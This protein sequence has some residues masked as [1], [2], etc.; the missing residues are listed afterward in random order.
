MKLPYLAVSLVAFLLTAI[1]CAPPPP[2][3]H[4]VAP[5]TPTTA[6]TK[7]VLLYSLAFTAEGE[8]QYDPNGPFREVLERLTQDFQVRYSDQPLSWKTLGGAK[9][10]LI[11]NPCDKA[12]EG[13]A[14][15]RHVSQED[16]HLLTNYVQGGG[17]LIF[18]SNQSEAHNCE[19]RQANFLLNQF[20]MGVTEYTIGV[21]KVQIPADAPIVGGLTWAFYYGSPLMVNESHF[22][23]PRVLVWNDPNVPAEPKKGADGLRGPILA[24][25][26]VG[27]GRV[28]LASDSGW[29]AQWALLEQEPLGT[30]RGQDNWEIFRRLARWTAGMKPIAPTT[31][32]Q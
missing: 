30:L 15:P 32:P 20:G 8:K 21:K 12:F 31:Q 24:V 1:C 3:F 7:P 10:V 2:A 13:H 6:A 18:L 5:R 23:H 28:V 19:K 17:G 14:P 9:V 26:E 29:I 11:A 4:T 25:A 27:K 16:I 22:A